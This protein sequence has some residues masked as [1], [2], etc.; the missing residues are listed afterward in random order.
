MTAPKDLVRGGFWA[1]GLRLLTPFWERDE[2][3]SNLGSVG[4]VF[5]K[6]VK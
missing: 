2:R 5:Q 4:D 1:R 6:Y 3:V